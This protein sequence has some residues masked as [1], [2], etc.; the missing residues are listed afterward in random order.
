MM[1]G[2]RPLRP[3]LIPLGMLDLFDKIEEAAQAITAVF[4]EPPK[5]AIILGTGLGNLVEQIDVKASIDY[6]DIPH[7]LK[8]TATSH[9]GRWYVVT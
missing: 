6:G 3:T 9:R 5:V 2:F 8:S 4:P 1:S 7:F